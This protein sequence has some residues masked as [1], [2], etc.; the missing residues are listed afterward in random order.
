MTIAPIGRLVAWR[1]VAMALQ[2]CVWYGRGGA[3]WSGVGCS[4]GRA[5]VHRRAAGDSSQHL[6]EE[7]VGLILLL[8]IK[9]LIRLQLD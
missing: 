4:G 1:G 3:G 9:Q 7:A 2:A 5:P 6:A 8:S